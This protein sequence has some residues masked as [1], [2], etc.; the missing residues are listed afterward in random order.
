VAQN[1]ISVRRGIWLLPGITDIDQ[2]WQLMS[3]LNS[4]IGTPVCWHRKADG[5]AR[6]GEL[7]RYSLR[8]LN[9]QMLNEGAD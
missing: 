3:T 5:S 4:N 8:K 7:H 1:V 6:Y 9:R 2:A